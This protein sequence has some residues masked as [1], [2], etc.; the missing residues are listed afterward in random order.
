MPYNMIACSIAL[1]ENDAYNLSWDEIIALLQPILTT[2]DV[3]ALLYEVAI[4][5]FQYAPPFI[6]LNAYHYICPR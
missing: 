3:D 6:V 2:G 1:K 4:D 5:T